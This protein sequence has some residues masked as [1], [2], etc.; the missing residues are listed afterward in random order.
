M[1]GKIALHDKLFEYKDAYDLDGAI[2]LFDTTIKN[3]LG[4]YASGTKFQ[5]VLVSFEDSKI[6]FAKEIDQ[7]E[8]DLVIGE[9]GVVLKE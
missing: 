5:L 3:T 2:I 9:E 1:A 4:D 6:W 8:L 7:H